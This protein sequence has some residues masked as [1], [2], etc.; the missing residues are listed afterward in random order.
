VA[1]FC[2]RVA[3]DAARGRSTRQQFSKRR[4]TMKT[5]SETKTRYE[6]ELLLWP[7]HDSE[8]D[9]VQQICMTHAEHRALKNHLAGIRK[10]NPV[11]TVAS[12]ERWGLERLAIR[13]APH[14]SRAY[15]VF[16]LPTAGSRAG[17]PDWMLETPDCAYELSVSI[18]DSDCVEEI[19]VTREEYIS[20]K[21]HLASM[22]ARPRRGKAA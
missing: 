19:Q 21:Q 14:Q 5:K 17:K 8:A 11:K 16:G 22:R 1:D 6:Y 9:T 12:T 10:L 13:L 2:F 4:F 20:L 18:V 15:G 7:P 3:P